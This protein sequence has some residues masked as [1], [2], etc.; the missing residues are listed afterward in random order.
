LDAITNHFVLLSCK[1]NVPGARG[2][3]RYEQ[4]TPTNYSRAVQ[5]PNPWRVV[6]SV[7]LER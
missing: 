1:T 3:G 4:Q 5:W 2:D 7:L 6:G